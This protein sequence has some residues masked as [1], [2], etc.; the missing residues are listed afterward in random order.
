MAEIRGARRRSRRMCPTGV[1][2]L[3]AVTLVSALAGAT[4]A[5]AATTTVS[6]G[7]ELVQAIQDANANPG[8]DTIVIA[9]EI[10][11]TE[12]LPQIT[13][14]LTI[15]GG[16][17]LN[18]DDSYAGLN[19]DGAEAFTV[20][21][22]AI[23]NLAGT[24]IEVDGV[25]LVTIDDVTITDVTGYGVYTYSTGDDVVSISEVKVAR[26]RYE[27]VYVRA[28][29]AATASIS[30]VDVT[31]SGRVEVTSSPR[32]RGGIAVMASRDAS[33]ALT[34][35]TYTETSTVRD[36]GLVGS[37]PEAE[38]DLHLL[39]AI[40]LFAR[41]RGQVQLSQAEVIAPEASGIR[42]GIQITGRGDAAVTVTDVTG[43]SDAE[44]IQ[45][46]LS[47]RAELNVTRLMLEGLLPDSSMGGGVAVGASDHASA[48]I[49]DFDI[50]N[51]PSS[52]GFRPSGTAT[53][54]VAEGV[55]A[56][57][58]GIFGVGTGE[59]EGSLFVRDVDMSNVVYAGVHGEGLGEVLVDSVTIDGS[60]GAGVVGAGLERGLVVHNSTIT[61]TEFAVAGISSNAA[62]V[63][64]ESSTLVNNEE[65]FI[66]DGATVTVRNSIISTDEVVPLGAVLEAL[67]SSH[68][69]WNGVDEDAAALL[70]GDGNLINVDPQL[71]ALADNGGFT[72][73]MLPAADSPVIDAG[74]DTD[75]VTDQRGGPRVIGVLDLGSVEVGTLDEDPG[76][77]EEPGD[78]EQP[79][80]GEPGGQQPGDEIPGGQPGDE[81]T[82]GG[83]TGADPGA[84]DE[85][86]EAVTPG[87]SGPPLP[88]T[89]VDSGTQL[90]VTAGLGVFL[91]GGVLLVSQRGV[92][93]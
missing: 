19:V 42:H 6:T 79:G 36:K 67:S 51:S 22:L 80:D 73:T 7:A 26:A 18:G 14:T 50:T 8:P 49:T 64:I 74:G 28:F 89:G 54:L 17:S 38:A 29:S 77:D 85:D 24:A 5:A 2:G 3:A 40:A 44:F 11:L 71:G 48:I 32:E 78:E 47:D 75:L 39:P 81:E 62:P 70:A 88:A 13:D 68:T 30:N 34:N 72:R 41:D 16:G 59:G 1:A 84:S 66:L 27:G 63:L 57:S 46:E 35:I 61:G 52:I 9:D 10:V 33:V 25:D 45:A 21:D 31:D 55:I 69:L 87:K 37:H 58:V 4:S 76:D 93:S 82:P 20:R 86:S 60:I 56:N 53:L 91:L 65:L 15:E 12:P 23:T 90:A 43:S 92:R 83:S